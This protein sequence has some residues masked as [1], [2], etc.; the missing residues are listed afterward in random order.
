MKILTKQSL[1]ILILTLLLTSC[2]QVHTVQVK[3]CPKTIVHN[4]S[5]E[6]WNEKDD[7]V[8]NSSKRRCRNH[9]PEDP[10]LIVLY[11]N[12]ID[13]YSAICG[14]HEPD[15]GEKGKKGLEREYEPLRMSY[16]M[17]PWVK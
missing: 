17:G 4:S 1:G 8:L 11:K 9:F 10:C 12:A 15:P 13:S 16:R 2:A 7:V 6:P 14:K 3:F 5:P